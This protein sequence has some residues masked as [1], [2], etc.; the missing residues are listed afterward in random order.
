MGD[1]HLE[2]AHPSLDGPSISRRG[3][4]QMVGST[5]L[6]GSHLEMVVPPSQDEFIWRCKRDGRISGWTPPI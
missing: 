5:S 3:H 2:M 4:L 6:D 1:V